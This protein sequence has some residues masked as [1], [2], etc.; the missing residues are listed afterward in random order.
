MLLLDIEMPEVSGV[1]V[2]ERLQE[3][4]VRI[5]ALSSYDDPEYAAGLLDSGASGYLTKEHAPLLILEAVRAVHRGDVR[6]FVQPERDVS[7]LDALTDREQDVLRRLAQGLSNAEIGDAL[8]VSV[9]TIRSHVA[10]IYA[11][12]DVDSGREAIA[13]AWQNGVMDATRT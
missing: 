4:P 13:W 1:E 2:A 10:N 7:K 5:L 11:K 3:H 9:H 12:L 6:W 8:N